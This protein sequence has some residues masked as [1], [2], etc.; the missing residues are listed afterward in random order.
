MAR[1]VVKDNITSGGTLD[2]GQTLRL[3]GFI[4]AA[5]SAAVL[6]MTSQ[7]IKN[8]LRVSPEFTE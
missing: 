3:G 1:L 8:N 7:V 6:T 5:R 2:I 4:M